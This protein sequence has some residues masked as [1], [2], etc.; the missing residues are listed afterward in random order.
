MEHQ[1]SMEH[2]DQ[3]EQV[4]MDVWQKEYQSD[5]MECHLTPKLQLMTF[6]Q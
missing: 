1:P 3:N 5:Y 4:A 6:F 2:N